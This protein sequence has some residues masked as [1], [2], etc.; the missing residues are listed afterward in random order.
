M[1]TR[2]YLRQTDDGV[3]ALDLPEALVHDHVPLTYCHQLYFKDLDSA[4]SIRADQLVASRA[5]PDGLVNA[6]ELMR[7]AAAGEIERRA[8]ITVRP[9]ADARF[10]VV[11]GNSTF[12][13]GLAS[14]WPDLPCKVVNETASI[15]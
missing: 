4:V 10:L 1:I 6:N 3:R 11:D 13:N 9:L 14:G 8:P 7:R 2:T 15:G 12:L 5:R